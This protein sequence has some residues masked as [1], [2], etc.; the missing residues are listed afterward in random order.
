M[1]LSTVS[2]THSFILIVCD[3]CCLSVWQLLALLCI[4]Y[5][6]RA[7]GRSCVGVMGFWCGRTGVWVLGVGWWWW[8]FMAGGV[9]EELQKSCWGIWCGR[10]SNGYCLSILRK[11]KN[12]PLC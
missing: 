5:V 11:C 4:C 1:N 3:V 9:L 10:R 8:G 6:T 12:V 7:G 2:D